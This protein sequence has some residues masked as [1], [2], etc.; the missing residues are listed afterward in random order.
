MPKHRDLLRAANKLKS[1][2]GSHLNETSLAIGIAIAELNNIRDAR[3]EKFD[4]LLL[5]LDR[6]ENVSGW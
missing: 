3:R 4:E 1:V 6:A 2:K 5:A